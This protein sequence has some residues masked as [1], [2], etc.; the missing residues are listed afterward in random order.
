MFEC[1]QMR[2]SNLQ[3]SSGETPWDSQQIANQQVAGLLSRKQVAQILGTCVH[4]IARNKRLSPIRFN[5][6]LL[7]YRSE[8]VAR[9]IESAMQSRQEDAP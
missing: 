2:K 3:K 4:T 9:F 5:A 6:R 1:G 7:R 8:D